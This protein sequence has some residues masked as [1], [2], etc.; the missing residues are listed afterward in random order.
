MLRTSPPPRVASVLQESYE[1]TLPRHFNRDLKK[2]I[3]KEV[4]RM[5]L[6]SMGGFLLMSLYDVIDIFWLA[7]LGPEPVAAV[8]VFTSFLYIMGVFNMI[9]G[10]GSV[11]IISR[12]FGEGNAVRT[13]QSIKETILLKFAFGTICGGIALLLLD[14]AM[15]YMGAAP[16]VIPL[17]IK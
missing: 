10:I 2:Q 1:G 4:L 14:W 7:K 16:D 5:G 9:V 12:R 8:T 17:A 11:S 3:Y 13:E 6:P 15:H